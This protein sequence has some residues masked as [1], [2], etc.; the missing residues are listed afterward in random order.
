[1]NRLQGFIDPNSGLVT[2]HRDS[3]GRDCD[4]HV[5]F[6]VTAGVVFNMMGVLMTPLVGCELEPGVF[7]RYP[8]DPQPSSWD[9]HLAMAVANSYDA[10]RIKLHGETHE[11]KWGNEYLG[12]IPLF[13]STVYAASGIKLGLVDQ[14]IM[15]ACFIQNV[16]ERKG[17]TSG[18]CLLYLA[19][20]A[21]KGQGWLV[22][23]CVGA[24]RAIMGLRYP[25][26]MRDVYAIYF[27]PEHPIALYGPQGFEPI[28]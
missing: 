4:N 21:L 18:T 22:M 3:V 27:G 10:T 1:M 2:L 12:R 16:F 9:D 8:D 5:L 6:T 28:G 17:E 15:G 24:W 25:G 14:A 7:S 19:Q 23:A 11:W 26:G 13:T 20:H